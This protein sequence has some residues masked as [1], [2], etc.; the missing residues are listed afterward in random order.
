MYQV[1]GSNC[2]TGVIKLMLIFF[3]TFFMMTLHNIVQALLGNK[4]KINARNEDE[5]T[6]LHLA[7]KNGKIRYTHINLSAN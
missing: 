1:W 3:S 7:A 6:P 2:D 5:N 4:A